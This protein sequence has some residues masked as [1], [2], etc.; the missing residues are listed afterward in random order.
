MKRGERLLEEGG[1]KRG[2]DRLHVACDWSWLFSSTCLTLLPTTRLR[3]FPAFSNA[4]NH[5]ETAKGGK[6]PPSLTT[7]ETS[8]CFWNYRG[9]RHG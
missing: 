7:R 3:W 6:K 9:A 1:K 8:T 5:R 4:E 2:K